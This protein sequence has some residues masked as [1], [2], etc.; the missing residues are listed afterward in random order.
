MLQKSKFEGNQ[1]IF[2]ATS[3]EVIEVSNICSSNEEVDVPEGE[4]GDVYWHDE[5]EECL[6]CFGEGHPNEAD[7]SGWGY[8]TDEEGNSLS[9]AECNS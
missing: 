1:I 2:I 7:P 6:I 8:K 9:E 5:I 4:Q 3:F